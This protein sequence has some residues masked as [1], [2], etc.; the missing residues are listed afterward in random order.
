[1][2]S[3]LRPHLRFENFGILSKH[4]G[5]PL[6]RGVNLSV[7]AGKPFCLAGES[8]CGKSLLAQAV[9]GI[10]PEELMTEGSIFLNGEEISGLS[11]HSPKR[12]RDLWGRKVFYMPQEPAASLNPSMR[13]YRQILEIHTGLLRRTRREGM[14]LVREVLEKLGLNLDT[15]GRE[16]PH[17]LSGGMNQRILLAMALSSPA[18]LIIVDEPTKGLESSKRDDAASLLSKLVE[19]GRTVLCITHDLEIPK[20]LGGTLAMMYGGLIAETGSVSDVLERPKHVYTRGFLRALPENG[21]E[22][23][24]DTVLNALETAWKKTA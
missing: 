3:K 16:Y 17:R 21:L 18:E 6:V 14:R 19:E 1:M 7:A 9:V 2:N 12:L 13:A 15:A 8:G 22:P 11:E 23:I 5:Q 10:L 4:S 24:P 20:K